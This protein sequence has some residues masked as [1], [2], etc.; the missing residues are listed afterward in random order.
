M[1]AQDIQ[2]KV[3]ELKTILTH[4][5]RE[6]GGLEKELYRAISDYQKALEREKLKEIKES[7]S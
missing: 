2:R 6:L 5:K 3:A 7:I 1:R 4:Y